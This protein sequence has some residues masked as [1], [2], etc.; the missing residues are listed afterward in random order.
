MDANLGSSDPAWSRSSR[1]IL[2]VQLVNGQCFVL[3]MPMMNFLTRI[4]EFNDHE[5]TNMH[6]HLRISST[7]L[8]VSCK[9]VLLMPCIKQS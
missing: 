9:C 4:F 3:V 1:L 8:S 5:S 6:S 7:A 2:A